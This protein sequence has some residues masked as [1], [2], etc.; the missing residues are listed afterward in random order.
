MVGR[1]EV[2]A[3]VVLEPPELAQVLPG[4]EALAGAGEHDRTDLL[5]GRLLERRVQRGVHPGRE[6]VVGV[7]TVERDRQDGAVAAGLD[8]GHAAD[9]IVRVVLWDPNA[10]EPL[11]AEWDEGAALAALRA[12]AADAEEAFDDGW[13]IH[14]R[15]QEPGEPERWGGTYLGGAGIV[16]ALRRL[17]ER[18]LVELRRDYL[19]LRR[20]AG[21]G[22]AGPE[23]RCSARRGSCSSGTGCRPPPRHSNA[24]ASSSQRTSATRNVSSC[25]AAPGRCSP[26]ASS[27]SRISGRRRPTRCSRL[28]TR[29]RAC[30]QHRIWGKTDSYVRRCARIRRLRAGARRVRGRRRD[31]AALRDRRGRPGELAARTPTASA[32]GRS[33][34]SGA[35]AR[36]G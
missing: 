13:R 22:R 6:R 15:D 8:V 11:A 28:A 33:A 18:D 20:A 30:G 32:A 35:T 17:A 3:D 36:P 12:I 1:L 5:V 29:R 19:P 34:C 16:D 9:P 31:R 24:C 2:L 10:H 7:R 27:A 23:P 21:A 4:A 14:P 25:S 26:P